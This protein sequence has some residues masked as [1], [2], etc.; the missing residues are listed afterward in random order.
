MIMMALKESTRAMH[1]RIE[2]HVNLPGR[3]HSLHDY[4][5]L[6]ERLYGFYEPLE[7]HRNRYAEKNQRHCG[8]DR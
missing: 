2:A 8:D 1:E 3:L 7:F 4:R 5:Q 6:L